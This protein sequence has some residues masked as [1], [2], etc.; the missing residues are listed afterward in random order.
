MSNDNGPAEQI[1][2]PQKDSIWKANREPGRRFY[3]TGYANLHVMVY[4]RMVLFEEIGHPEL[5]T[6]AAPLKNWFTA[7]TSLDE[8]FAGYQQPNEG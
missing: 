1:L 3:V 4:P 5:G 8:F 7:M 2:V 6:L